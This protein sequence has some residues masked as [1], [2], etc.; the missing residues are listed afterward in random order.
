[1]SDNGYIPEIGDYVEIIDDGTL[2]YGSGE[3]GECVGH[4]EGTAIIR[5]SY[6]LGCFYPKVLRRARTERER[7]ALMLWRQI[8]KSSGADDDQIL[9]FGRGIDG[10]FDC[11]DSGWKPKE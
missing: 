10:V 3:S 11:I 2:R 8:F 5:M 4:I 9:N 1:M 7:L 6:G